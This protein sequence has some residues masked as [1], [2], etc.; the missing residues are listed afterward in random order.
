MHDFCAC[1]PETT[2]L[3]KIP[4][5]ASGNVLRTIFYTMYHDEENVLCNDTQKH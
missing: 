2:L 1:T 4:E 5:Q 3:L